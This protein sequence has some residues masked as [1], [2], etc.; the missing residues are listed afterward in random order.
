MTSA[1]M[2]ELRELINLAT[3]QPVKIKS[4]S[5]AAACYGKARFDSHNHAMRAIKPAKHG[6]V[7]A[8]RCKH[9]GG[10]HLGTRVRTWG[11][12]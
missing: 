8:Y 2:Q 5:R 12:R 7:N 1:E 6:L 4:E 11:I 10:W 9:C 3:S